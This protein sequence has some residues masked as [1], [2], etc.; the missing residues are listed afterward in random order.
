MKNKILYLDTLVNDLYP[1]N[2]EKIKSVYPDFYECFKKIR[3]IPW[4][5][6]WQDGEK[7]PE[8]IEKIGKL[9]KQLEN[10]KI[11]REEFE[12]ELNN[13]KMKTYSSRIAGIS[14]M[15]EKLVAFRDKNPPFNII[16]HEAG[17][18]Y[19][20]V[21]DNVWNASYGGAEILLWLGL[22]GRY[23]I[24]EE[25]VRQYIKLLKKAKKDETYLEAADEITDKLYPL[26]N[27][28]ITKA[29]YPIYLYIGTIPDKLTEKYG[30]KVMQY[31]LDSPLWTNIKPIKEDVWMFLTG[32]IA[33]LQYNDS[34]CLTY[35]KKLGIIG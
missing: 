22:N 15:D 6:G 9:N 17:H 2:A 18:I 16:I 35:S 21:Y 10:K 25:N 33:G 14:F 23:N 26:L 13:P 7:N 4:Q 19:F 29:F 27:N 20:M 12:K 30:M 3:I 31:K 24:K 8:I 28:Q 1:E 32:I 5:A 34:F 11:T